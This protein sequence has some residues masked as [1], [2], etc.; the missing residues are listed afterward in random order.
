[1]NP[2]NALPAKRV[3]VIVAVLVLMVAGFTGTALT[4]E[5]D[6]V[7]FNGKIVTLD[8]VRAPPGLGLFP[9]RTIRLKGERGD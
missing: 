6:A 9:M 8:D 4:A 1:M 5:P 2:V 7:Y 3:G